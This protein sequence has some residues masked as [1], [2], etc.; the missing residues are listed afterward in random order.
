MPKMTC[1]TCN[2]TGEGEDWCT[3]HALRTGH[4]EYMQEAR[5]D[6][7]KVEIGFEPP[8]VTPIGNMNDLL[9]QV[10]LPKT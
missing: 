5:I 4:L 1:Q 10:C 2:Q 8:K 9:A 7:V 3:V 6:F